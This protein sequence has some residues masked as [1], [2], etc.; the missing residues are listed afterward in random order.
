MGCIAKPGSSVFPCSCFP[1]G[2]GSMSANWLTEP[3]SPL[4]QIST[5]ERAATDSAERER[6]RERHLLLV[7]S[8]GTLYISS[9]GVVGYIHLAPIDPPN[10]LQ[11][12]SGSNRWMDGAAAAAVLGA[13][14]RKSLAACLPVPSLPSPCLHKRL[15]HQLARQVRPITSSS[16]RN[17]NSS[18]THCVFTSSHYCVAIFRHNDLDLYSLWCHL[19][20][21]LVVVR[22]EL[23]LLARLQT[24]LC[25][26][27]EVMRQDERIASHWHIPA[28]EII[29]TLQK[30]CESIIAGLPEDC[31]KG[32]SASEHQWAHTV[33][34]NTSTTTAAGLTNFR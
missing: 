32:I 21:V 11:L 3:F 30:H 27:E 23:L 10:G 1:A 7:V 8:D 25:P 24:T 31:F 14:L 29:I 4:A 26:N 16:S 13:A 22:G 33:K 34:L 15:R 17:S 9:C 12:A 28:S 20:V 5:S 2:M 18:S 6:E 19:L